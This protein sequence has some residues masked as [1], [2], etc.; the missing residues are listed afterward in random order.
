MYSRLKKWSLLLLAVMSFSVVLAA[1]GDSTATP[2]TVNPGAATVP[3]GVKSALANYF[4]GST[5]VYL[6]VNTD[7][8]SDQA[9]SLQ[10]VIDYLSNIPEVKDSLSKI[11]VFKL[12]GLGS[13]DADI[14]PWL[15][16]E[17]AVGLTDLTALA[18]LG[19]SSSNGG[20]GLNLPQ[21]ELPVL[22]AAVVTDQTKADAFLTKIGSLLKLL[23]PAAPVEETYKDTKLT[24]YDL[25]GFKFTTGLGK[26]KLFIGGSATAIKAALDRTAAQSLASAANYQAV[27]AKLPQG[28]LGFV[29]LDGQALNSSLTSSAQIKQSLGNMQLNGLDYTSGVGLTLATADEGLRVDAYQTY[30]TAKIPTGVADTFKKG[31]NPSKIINALPES[32]MFF[33]NQRDAASSYDLII[34]ALK[35]SNM[36]DMSNID[37]KIADFE[38]Q[39]G[40][41]VRNDIVSLFNGEFAVFATPDSANQKFPVGIGLLSEVTDKAASQAKLDKIATS[42]ENNSNGQI[43]WQTK[44]S[45]NVTY[46]SAT[47]TQNNTTVSLNLGLAGNASNTSNYAFLI[48]GDDATS[49]ALAAIGGGKN[50]LTGPNVANF[51]KVKDVLPS[52]NSGYFFVDAQA[53]FKLLNQVQPAGKAADVQKYTGKLDKLY[54]AGAA[55]RQNLNEAYTTIY[56]YFPVTK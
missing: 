6:A 18:N 41:S 50:F 52:D 10:K 3:T 42:L 35:N 12:G 2:L 34:N 55:T 24:T 44:T 4:P 1:C 39:A 37:Q 29:Y 40:L 11:D 43:K 33:V 45:G 51:N 28:N 36:P 47:V 46:R 27:T 21:G 54:A 32:T 26:D 25:S 56:L 48:A 14:K 22:I 53:A 30:L 23:N 9:K 20:S 49:G 31:A 38:K 16:N 5:G 8:N 15:G 19:N 17:L 13:Y 7:A